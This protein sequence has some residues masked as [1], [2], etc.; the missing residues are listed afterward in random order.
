MSSDAAETHPASAARSL[1]WLS[2]HDCRLESVWQL[3]RWPCRMST[4]SHCRPAGSQSAVSHH[5]TRTP[6]H[7]SCTSHCLSL[8]PTHRC[9]PASSAGWACG[10]WRRWRTHRCAARTRPPTHPPSNPPQPCAGRRRRRPR[11]PSGPGPCRS[12]AP[13]HW[14]RCPWP[15]CH[16]PWRGARQRPPCPPP[17]A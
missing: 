4:R 10:R 7:P 1:P 8:R 5:R 11:P 3:S 16:W 14:P 17:T 2:W 13:R 6:S 15:H 12:P 9:L